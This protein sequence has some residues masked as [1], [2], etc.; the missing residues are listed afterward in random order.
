MVLYFCTPVFKTSVDEPVYKQE[1][2][3][4]WFNE[5]D[6]I[7]GFWDYMNSIDVVIV[8]NEN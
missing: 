1:I 2:A 4:D 8:K 7:T 6:N 5:T 3:I